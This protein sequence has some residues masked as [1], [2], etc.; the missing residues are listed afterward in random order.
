[1]SRDSCYKRKDSRSWRGG[2]HGHGNGALTQKT[3]S[4]TSSASLQ[5]PEP[6]GTRL[7]YAGPTMY[8]RAVPTA[9]P[10]RGPIRGGVGE[11][12]V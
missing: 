10:V 2:N 8:A 11:P 1:M 5:M 7:S 4:S 3:I 12:L 6:A 9:E